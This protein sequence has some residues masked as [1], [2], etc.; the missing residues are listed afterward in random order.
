MHAFTALRSAVLENIRARSPLSP[1]RTDEIVRRYFSAVPSYVKVLASRWGFDRLRV[2][3]IGSNYGQS[4][5]FWGEGGEGVDVCEEAVAFTNACG[6]KTHL[7]NIDNGPLPS[8]KYDAVFTNNLFEHVVAPHLFLAKIFACLNDGGVLA[9]GYPVVPPAAVRWLWRMA[10]I[11]P[12]LAPEHVNFYSLQSAR[13]F[14]QRAGF[15]VIGQFAPRPYE[16][17]PLL[18]AAI[19]P[20]YIHCFSVCRKM[21]GFKYPPERLPGHDPAFCRDD[22]KIYR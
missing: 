17:H 2:L 19:L 10:G 1:G 11:A 9:I 6:R 5:F 8:A 16:C 20:W 22:L 14:L 13:C 18:S 3:D 15:R 7:V 21:P 4:L 12:W